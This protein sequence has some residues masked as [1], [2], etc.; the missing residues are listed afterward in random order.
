VLI[1]RPIALAI[2]A[3][4]VPLPGLLVSRLTG[5]PFL[6]G[7]YFG[8]LLAGYLWFCHQVRSLIWL[9]G[10]VGI[11]GIVCLFA[12]SLTTVFSLVEYFLTFLDQSSGP[13]VVPFTLAGGVGATVIGGLFLAL[14]RRTVPLGDLVICALVGAGLGAIG[15][16][17]T[18][19]QVFDGRLQVSAGFLPPFIVWQGG[20][21]FVMALLAEPAR[22]QIRSTA[23]AFSSVT[24]AVV[25]L[26]LALMVGNPEAKTPPK[27]SPAPVFERPPSTANLP[28]L[29]ERGDR[30]IPRVGPLGMKGEGTVERVREQVIAA[31]NEWAIVDTLVYRASYVESDGASVVIGQ[32]PTRAWARYGARNFTGVTIRALGDGHVLADAAGPDFYWLSGDQL[33]Y[34]HGRRDATEVLAIAYL[35]KYPSEID[36]AFPLFQQP[37]SR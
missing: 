24:L 14:A 17:V 23:V 29:I 37:V 21:A 28:D 1:R 35:K 30:F 2:G 13:D 5:Y 3:A 27:P 33:I 31:A 4:L 15:R 10:L 34:V 26:G 19:D 32:Y 6:D 18:D 16:S 12:I 36:P 20:M 8:I 22:Q 9:L 11:S 7:F 25:A